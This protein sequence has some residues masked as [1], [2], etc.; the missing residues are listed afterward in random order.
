MLRMPISY[1]GREKNWGLKSLANNKSHKKEN[2]DFQESD[3][4]SNGEKIA[5]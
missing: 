4:R 2:F 5:V 1:K 3:E